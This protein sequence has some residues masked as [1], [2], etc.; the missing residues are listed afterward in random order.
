ME[1]TSQTGRQ[2]CSSP[3][4]SQNASSTSPNPSP[5]ALAMVGAQALSRAHSQPPATMSSRDNNTKGS[6]DG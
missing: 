5:T 2:I 4:S 1:D 6:L 3:P